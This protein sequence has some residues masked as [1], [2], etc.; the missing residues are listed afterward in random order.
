MKEFEVPVIDVMDIRVVDPLMNE[1]DPSLGG[2]DE[3]E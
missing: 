1:V 3:Y 2:G